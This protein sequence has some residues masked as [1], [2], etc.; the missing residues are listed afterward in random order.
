VKQS[1]TLIPAR[2]FSI[3]MLLG[4]CL[5]VTDI[6]AQ[7]DMT[8][9]KVLPA[10]PE[11]QV[12][13][14]AD[15]FREQPQKL[16]NLTASLQRI[17]EKHDYKVYLAVYYNILDGTVQDRA[18]ELYQAWLGDEERGLVIV[19]QKDPAI[20]G[21]N[22]AAS[23]FQGSGLE[24]DTETG[25]VPDREMNG[26]IRSALAVKPDSNDIADRCASIIN[27]VDLQ[28][29]K[30]FAIEPAK[31]SD[32]ANLKMMA[33]FFG[34]IALLAIGGAFLWKHF[35]AAE[36]KSQ[37]YFTFPMVDVAQR[38]GAP[39]GGGWGSEKSFQPSSSSRR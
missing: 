8:A 30:Y 38:L 12:L 26:I 10:R 17:Q 23:Y 37:Q 5:L 35:N 27:G 15:V 24:K 29:D 6:S 31:W 11:N 16:A 9:E 21:Q 28:M 14:K 4:L 34:V 20:D 3:F 39:Y 33:V 36:V 18:D 13:D 22:V 19:I 7:L 2:F 1:V 25:L 32:A